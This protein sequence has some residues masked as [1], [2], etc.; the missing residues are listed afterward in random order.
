V[1]SNVSPENSGYA[2]FTFL[3]VFLVT[4]QRPTWCSMAQ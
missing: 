2:T 3:L 1:Y 4:Q